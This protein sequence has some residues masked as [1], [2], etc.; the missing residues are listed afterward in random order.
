MDERRRTEVTEKADRAVDRMTLLTWVNVALAFVIAVGAWV[1]ADIVRDVR[2]EQ[3]A[4]R[5]RGYLNRAESCRNQLALVGRDRLGPGCLDRALV[6][7]GYFDPNEDL[8]T[9]AAERSEQ[10]VAVMCAFAAG[11]EAAVPACGG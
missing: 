10:L 8:K 3:Q 2:T 9:I 11:R 4:G 6:E 7:G 5:E 1:G